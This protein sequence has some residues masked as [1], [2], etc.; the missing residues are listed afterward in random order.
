M[1]QVK[2]LG[3]TLFEIGDPFETVTPTMA[4]GSKYPYPMEKL[5]YESLKGS[6]SRERT[7]SDG[8]HYEGGCYH[9]IPACE[10]CKR[11]FGV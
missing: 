7:G 9:Q 6:Y 11:M 1:K 10:G 4:D 8:I 5:A 3:I 2:F